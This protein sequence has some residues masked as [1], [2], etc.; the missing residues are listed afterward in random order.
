MDSRR[1]PNGEAESNVA[2]TAWAVQ[3]LW[4]VG[5]NPETWTAGP[6]AREPLDYMES[7]QQPDGHIRWRA[8][9][10]MN[11]IWM[12]AYVT[13]AFDGHPLPIPTAARNDPRASH[14]EAAACLAS[15][16]NGGG[17]ESGDEGVISGGGG[18]GAPAFSRPKAQREGKT[19]G[20]A[21][22]VHGQSLRSRDHSR[23]RRGENETQPRGTETTEARRLSE[24]EREAPAV[25]HE[26]TE[27]SVVAAA[28]GAGDN[29]NR[30]DGPGAKGAP[31]EVEKPKGAPAA[32]NDREVNGVLIGSP[33]G[34]EGQLAFGAPG[35]RTSGRR[36]R[37]RRSGRRSRSV[38]P[39]S[40][41]RCLGAG[42]ERRRGVLA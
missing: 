16:T 17:G 32:T 9:D 14:G 8:K 36:K 31:V 2:S 28:A 42:M 30:G 39:P 26:A 38:P 7:M 35:L 27:G 24:A 13:P 15:G 5:Q 40:W 20:G 6:E 22:L 34:D 18:Q 29:G 21:R 33:D 3:A 41:R 4:A 10:D 19:P 25:S 37:R 23:S 12:T 11:G 1:C